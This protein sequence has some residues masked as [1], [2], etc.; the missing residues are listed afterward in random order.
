[1]DA[2]I[3]EGPN[4]Y[5]NQLRAMSMCWSGLDSMGSYGATS[6][7]SHQSGTCPTLPMTI[8]TQNDQQQHALDLILIIL[9][10]INEKKP[11]PVPENLKDEAYRERR[12]KN[13]ESARKSR[14]LRRQKEESTQLRCDQLQQENHILRA[15][16]SL[17]RNQME[18]F[19]QI[20]SIS[21]NNLQQNFFSNSSVPGL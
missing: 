11:V 3:R 1:M 13:N 16:L 21:S 19:R 17:L 8:T 4:C 9:P 7:Y 10:S 14:E 20:F 5:E 18:Q 12:M 15:E 6:N 2:E